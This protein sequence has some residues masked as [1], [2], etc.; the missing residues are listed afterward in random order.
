MSD[1][2]VGIS[3]GCFYYM[4][5]M[6]CLDPICQG[7]FC[8][9]EVCSSKAHLDYH[10]KP[11]VARVRDAL[12]DRGMEPYSLHAPFREDIDITSPDKATRDHSLREVLSAAEAAVTLE[13]RY[14]VFHPGPE[15][16]LEPPPEERLQRMY[17]AAE[18]LTEVCRY[19]RHAGVGLVVENMLPHLLFGNMRDM[20]WVIGAV[21]SLDVGACLDTGHAFLSGDIYQVMYKLSGHLQFLHVNDNRGRHDDHLPPPQ[22]NI[23]WS[24]LL[25]ELNEVDFHGALI[26]ELAGNRDRNPEDVLAEARQ[27]RRYLRDIARRLSLSTPPTVT[28]PA[29]EIPADGKPPI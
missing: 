14:F 22:G 26:L 3:T 17:N 1:W 27:A 24:M 8:M 23:N 6:D 15:K 16:S 12:S 29:S 25:H 18:V 11:A 2:P 10:D 20:L 21:D 7:G 19:C 5:L 28:V 13:A 9:I 4:D